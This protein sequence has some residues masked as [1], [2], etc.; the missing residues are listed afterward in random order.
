MHRPTKQ[1]AIYLAALFPTSDYHGTACSARH[2]FFLID[3]IPKKSWGRRCYP[4]H[5]ERGDGAECLQAVNQSL[6]SE[7]I[8]DLLL[9]YEKRYE[10]M[11]KERKH[12][13]TKARFL[14]LTKLEVT[15]QLEGRL[16]DKD[17]QISTLEQE[18]MQL[19]E[20]FE[21]QKNKNNETEKEKKHLKIKARFLK[22]EDA[23]QAMVKD[24]LTKLEA[25]EQLE[26]SLKEKDAEIAT[27]ENEIA[28]LSDLAGPQ[29]I[30]VEDS[31]N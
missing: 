24:E 6:I 1:S 8:R 10:A 18:I 31:N 27:L 22:E 17:A 9:E 25:V 26:N 30:K 5:G 2:L 13:K 3:C 7:E 21:M 4:G 15:E 19:N 12:L 16:R 20:M 14:K 23:T 28:E 29:K 11:E